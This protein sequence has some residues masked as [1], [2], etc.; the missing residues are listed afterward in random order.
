MLH[1]C[2]VTVRGLGC[3]V[4][5][6][7]PLGLW[8]RVSNLHSHTNCV[9]RLFGYVICKRRRISVSVLENGWL[10]LMMRFVNRQFLSVK[11]A[12][13]NQKYRIPLSDIPHKTCYYEQKNS[14][15]A[16]TGIMIPAVSLL[17]TW[18]NSVPGNSEKPY[19]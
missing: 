11:A 13:L 5:L 14:R 1:P 12:V 16:F 2:R 19:A 3:I 10:M 4:Y 18:F 8:A 9:C 7:P 6:P 17:S 15:F